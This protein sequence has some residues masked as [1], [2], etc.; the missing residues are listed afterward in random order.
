MMPDIGEKLA[1]IEAKGV[2]KDE[3][4]RLKDE[5][6]SDYTIKQNE[7]TP[8]INCSRPIHYSRKMWNMW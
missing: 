2:S 5:M 4:L 6:M 3:Q 7:F 8:L 1:E